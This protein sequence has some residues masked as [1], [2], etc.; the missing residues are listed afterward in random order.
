MNRVLVVPWSI[1][2][3][4]RGIKLI[5]IACHRE[6]GELGEDLNREFGEIGRSFMYFAS[7]ISPI[8]R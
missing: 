4:Y 7:L 2:P 8:S 5:P 1:A 6:I 3:I